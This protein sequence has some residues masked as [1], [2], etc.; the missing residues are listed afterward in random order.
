MVANAGGVR[1]T[2]VDFAAL[3]G[4]GQIPF[5]DNER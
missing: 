2:P 4:V 5:Q 1:Q 3:C